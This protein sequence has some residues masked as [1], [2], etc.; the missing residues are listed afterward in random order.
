MEDVE[1]VKD[2]KKKY[3]S[4]LG[5]IKLILNNFQNRNI[6]GDEKNESKGDGALPQI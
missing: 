4:E 3:Q 5:E 2:I 6:Y 1:K